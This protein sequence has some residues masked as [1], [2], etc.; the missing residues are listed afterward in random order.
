M[1]AALAAVIDT[2]TDMTLLTSQPA[3]LTQPLPQ[4]DRHGVCDF[5]SH[6]PSPTLARTQ[7]RPGARPR[8][9]TGRAAHD[10]LALAWQ[11][12]ARAARRASALSQ[13]KGKDQRPS[14]FAECQRAGMRARL[15][16]Q[17]RLTVPLGQQLQP[18]PR[19]HLRGRKAEQ[20]STRKA[21]QGSTKTSH[22]VTYAY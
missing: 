1:A 22:K 21:E 7:A 3:G 4:S 12:V 6:P 15:H 19:R 2:P 18:H 9:S 20:G 13:R 5:S 14:A 11:R 8:D 16:T 17:H 10:A